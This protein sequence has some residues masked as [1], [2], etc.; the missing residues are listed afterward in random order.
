MI[1]NNKQINKNYL[2]SF[3]N[4]SLHIIDNFWDKGKYLI[5]FI[6]YQLKYRQ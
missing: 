5:Y 3:S 2:D 4:K 1:M 6:I